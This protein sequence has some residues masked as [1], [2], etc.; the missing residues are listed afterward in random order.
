VKYRVSK[1]ARSDLDDIFK[2]WADRVGF[3]TAERLVDSIMERFWLAGEH[4][5]A[6]RS[7]QEIAPNVKCF[8]AGKYLIYYRKSKRAI[9]ILHIFH[10]ARNQRKA[11]GKQPKPKSR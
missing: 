3:R 4:P 9:D 6:V 2:Y 8:P 10:E 7:V 5:G 1:D 11:F